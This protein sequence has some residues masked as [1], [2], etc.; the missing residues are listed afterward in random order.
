MLNWT[1]S[2]FRNA[3]RLRW[4]GVVGCFLSAV[5]LTAAFGPVASLPLAILAALLV[6]E[7]PWARAVRTSPEAVPPKAAVD[8]RCRHCISFD[9]AE[10]QKLIQSA[11]HFPSWF[12][13]PDQVGVTYAEA[14]ARRKVSQM[15]DGTP[16]V[17]Q[18]ELTRRMLGG[19]VHSWKQYGIC[20]RGGPREGRSDTPISLNE[21]TYACEDFVERP[22]EG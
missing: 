21:F 11:G 17:P 20:S 14:E 1:F 15:P 18:A 13:S 9:L 16:D 8:H 19:R 4:V 3:K 12:L 6:P 22:K 2:T 5:A 7:F 10:G